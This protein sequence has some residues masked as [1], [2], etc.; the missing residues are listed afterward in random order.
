MLSVFFRNII[1]IN[2]RIAKIALRL[3]IY[4]D[5]HALAGYT[6][7][8]CFLI[9]FEWKKQMDL[10][11]RH[12][13]KRFINFAICP[14]TAKISCLR[15][16]IGIGAGDLKG[17]V[18]IQAPMFTSFLGMIDQRNVPLLRPT[19]CRILSQNLSYWRS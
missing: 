17:N 9:F 12:Q 14:R 15:D 16:N 1:K 3:R 7:R 10:K 8:C 4:A 19:L 5:N 13:L 11:L 18:I 6:L 2:R